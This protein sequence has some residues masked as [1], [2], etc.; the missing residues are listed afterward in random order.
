[1][2][3][4][5]LF[6]SVCVL[7]IGLFLIIVSVSEAQQN[8]SEEIKVFFSPKGGCAE[9]ISNEIRNANSSIYVCMYYLTS[10][11]L[12]KELINASWKGIEVK[13]VLDKSQLSSKY[14]KAKQLFFAKIPVK[15]DKKHRIMHNKYCIIDKKI[16]ITG[17]YNWT[18]SAELD[19]A[20][21]IVIIK[22][23][24]VAEEYL[25][26]FEKHWKH[27][28]DFKPFKEKI[29]P[30]PKPK[31]SSGTPKEKPKKS[32]LSDLPKEGYYIGNSK[33]KVF[34]RPNCRHARRI[35]PEYRVIFSTREEAINAGY[36]PCKVCKP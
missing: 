29:Q 1:M 13:V 11:K 10:K 32:D 4:K 18:K 23:R 26:D 5:L 3:K 27:S 31:K 7:F 24:K 8:Q 15:I 6:P 30:Q 16:V 28:V 34:H 36:R 22:N 20:E 21:N 35:K 17:S 19:N 12:S 33:S 14:S 2:L 9:A 25:E